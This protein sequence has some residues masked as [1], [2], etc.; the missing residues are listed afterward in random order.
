MRVTRLNKRIIIQR[1]IEKENEATGVTKEEWADLKTIW[2][3][4]NNLYG[5]EYWEAKQ[6]KAEGTVE[7]TMRYSACSD[8]SV[9]DRIKYNG[10]IFNITFVDN[11]QYKN[12]M[13]KIKAIEV[14][15]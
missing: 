4:M 8:L 12:E 3:G 14:A 11:V 13:L 1:K 15:T 9:R 5:K 10:K 2:A 6:Y 7:F